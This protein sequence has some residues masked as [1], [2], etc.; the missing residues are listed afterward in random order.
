MLNNTYNGWT[1]YE[2]WR[3]NLE[4]GLC[5]GGFEGYS[6]EM[7][8]NMVEEHLEED[9]NNKSTI[10]YALSFISEVNWNEIARNIEENRE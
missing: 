4:Y 9:C 8:Q 5:D 10:S 1:N 3:I 2:T 7:L 6:A